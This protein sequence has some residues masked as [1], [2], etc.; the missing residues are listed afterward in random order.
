MLK[1]DRMEK[2]YLRLFTEYNY[3]TTIWSPLAG[4][5]L[6]GKYNHGKIPESSRFAKH[7]IDF[8]W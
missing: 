4:G 8:V 3:G 6:T 2:E 7:D 1:R 5:L